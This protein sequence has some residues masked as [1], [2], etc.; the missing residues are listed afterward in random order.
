MTHGPQKIWDR[1][2]KY[3]F[4][5]GV[6][7]TIF[8]G[9]FS[10]IKF[11]YTLI[12]SVFFIS[13]FGLPH[14]ALDYKLLQRFLPK[15][16]RLSAIIG[17][18]LLV[19]LTLILWNQI[20]KAML[21]IFL[22]MSAYHFGGDWP[23]NFS[24]RVMSGFFMLG[25]PTV[26]YPQEVVSI[27]GFL[28][29]NPDAILIVESLQLIT[30]MGGIYLLILVLFR[31]LP[32]NQFFEISLLGCLASVSSPL[33]YFTTYFCLFHSL[34]HFAE[35]SGFLDDTGLI[36]LILLSLPVTVITL[37]GGVVF[38]GVLTESF[39]QPLDQAL[40]Q[41]TFIGL[42]AL[43]VPHMVF[44]EWIRYRKDVLATTK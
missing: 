38:V 28:I 40:I 20:P 24:R 44:V 16:Q 31:H 2:V 25:L 41:V 29:D 12:I 6:L 5:V 19:V 9:L 23:L 42:S 17:Y 35:I 13:V 21:V 30:L 26:F 22:I 11:S 8:M 1:L 43:T 39:R 36:K 7:V 3:A 32:S 37:I 27:F 4:F 33:I 18:V 34:K 14:G 15:E 10:P